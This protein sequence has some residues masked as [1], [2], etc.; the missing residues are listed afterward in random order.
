MS[1]NSEW[2]NCEFMLH[3]S[4]STLR[5]CGL[6][7]IDLD[8]LNALE[9]DNRF[10]SLGCLHHFCDIHGNCATYGTNNRS[11]LC[12]ECILPRSWAFMDDHIIVRWCLV[13]PCLIASFNDSKSLRNC[14]VSN[15]FLQTVPY[16]LLELPSLTIRSRY[17]S[18]FKKLPSYNN[19]CT[20]VLYCKL[21]SILSFAINFRILRSTYW[22]LSF[23]CPA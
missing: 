22:W 4:R 11:T 6:A 20:Y 16:K 17:F 10:Y 7:L 5:L 23:C 13:L 21:N 1:L 12:E 9:Y 2:N 19:F 18:F 14:P 8:V 3:I 15:I